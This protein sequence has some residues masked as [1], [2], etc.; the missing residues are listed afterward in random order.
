[1]NLTQEIH[2][3]LMLFT[4]SPSKDFRLDLKKRLDCLLSKKLNQTTR[5]K[6][7]KS[8]IEKIFN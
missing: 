8:K 2:L 6:S 5:R 4:Q 1:M 7:R 3:T